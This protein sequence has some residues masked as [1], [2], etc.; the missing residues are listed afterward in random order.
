MMNC[1]GSKRSI[2]QIGEEISGPIYTP[3]TLLDIKIEVLEK[4]LEEVLR[5]IKYISGFEHFYLPKRSLKGIVHFGRLEQSLFACHTR[6][7]NYVRQMLRNDR[8]L[9]IIWI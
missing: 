9:Q 4:A 7:L 3:I 1:F 5:I 6:K 8:S 2:L